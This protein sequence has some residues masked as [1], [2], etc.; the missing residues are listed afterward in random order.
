MRATVPSAL[1]SG[2]AMYFVAS[3]R[4]S[5]A[6]SS[7]SGCLSDVGF[8]NVGVVDLSGSDR[9]AL[10]ETGTDE[11]LNDPLIYGDCL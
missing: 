10:C 11:I 8:P 3:T 2:L 9:D 5:D 1:S 4:S 6:S 7:S